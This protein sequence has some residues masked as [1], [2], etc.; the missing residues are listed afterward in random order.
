M[1]IQ[2][3]VGYLLTPCHADGAVDEALLA[4]HVDRLIDSGVH[5]VAPLGSVGCLP[6]LTDDER[7]HVVRTVVTQTAGRVP[8]LVGISSLSTAQ[9]IRHA[10]FAQA[11]GAA[12]VQLLPSTYWQLTEDELYQYFKQVAEA[13]SI[14]IMAY[15]NP[16]TTGWDMSVPLLQR[17]TSLPNITMV[18]EASPDRSKIAALRRVCR[19]EVGIFVGLA[20][21]A[22]SGFADGAKGWCTAA[23]NVCP[24][25]VLKFY[26]CVAAGDAVGAA[27]W[28]ERQERLL[29]QLMEFGL[30]RAVA[31]GME[32]RGAPAGH[33]RLPLMPLGG[34]GRQALS[35]TIQN[36]EID[37]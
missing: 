19:E 28:F 3:I 6:Y 12:A 14:P 17:L 11:S 37:Q 5:G 1:T 21:M 32:I 26:E 15:N 27:R 8:V 13:I 16:F 24:E 29:N 33:L 31:A 9:T 2:G 30:P 4:R 20:K 36:M 7:D 25:H 10:K 34:E 23:P 18:K 22:Q 35:T